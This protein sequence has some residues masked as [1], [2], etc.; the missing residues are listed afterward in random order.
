MATE[1]TIT[2][3][4][5]GRNDSNTL[6]KGWNAELALQVENTLFLQLA[7]N[8]LTLAGHIAEGVG[9]VDVADNPR[10][11]IGLVE[12]GIDLEQHFHAST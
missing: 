10:E 2:R 3:S 8:L 6:G 12:L 7:D 1:I 4:I 9:R 5:L 11:T